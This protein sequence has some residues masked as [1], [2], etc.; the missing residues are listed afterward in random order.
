ME[1]ET[2][3]LTIVK[4]GEAGSTRQTFSTGYLENIS[5]VDETTVHP[6]KDKDKV[7]KDFKT[8]LGV[9]QLIEF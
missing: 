2:G 1:V 6:V 4:T 8:T 7:F 5:T 3:H 9:K